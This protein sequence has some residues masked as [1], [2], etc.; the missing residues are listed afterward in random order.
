MLKDSLG[1][2]RMLS[3][4]LGCPGILS[5]SSKIL[6]HSWTPVLHLGCLGILGDAQGCFKILTR[7][8][9]ILGGRCCI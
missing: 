9:I 5:D 7:F 4:S 2:S 3:D 6:D 1:C 8:R